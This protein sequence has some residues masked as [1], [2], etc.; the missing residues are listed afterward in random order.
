MS[1]LT[2]ILLGYVLP[3]M[4]NFTFLVLSWRYNSVAQWMGVIDKSYFK[5][6]L[7][8]SVVPLLNT[9]IALGLVMLLGWNLIPSPVKIFMKNIVIDKIKIKWPDHL[10]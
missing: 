8:W 9:V 2:L 6:F 3:L 7:G 5:M 1:G 10:K 4:V